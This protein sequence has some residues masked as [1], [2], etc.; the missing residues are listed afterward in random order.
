[1]VRGCC[2]AHYR[3]MTV[4]LGIL[5]ALLCAFVTNLAFLYKHRG[6]AVAP[7]VD[8]RRPI[9]SAKGLFRS[10]WFV[11]G[12]LVAV[13]AWVFHV[14][15]LAMAPI[16]VVQVVLASGLVLLAV[17][18]ERLFGFS[19]GKRQWAALI[20]MFV[21]LGLIAA[22]QPHVGDSNT[23]SI[24]AMQA[25]Q[26]CMV[27][28]GA[29]LIV[30][31]SKLGARP[32]SRGLALGAASGVLF[33]VSDVALKALTGQ[34]AIEGPWGVVSPSVPLALAASVGAFYASAR[35]LQVGEAVPVIA[36]TGTAANMVGI[37]GGILV[38]GDP[39]PS[40]T[41]GIAIQVFAFLL[42]IVAGAL[43]PAPVRAARV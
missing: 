41:M 27:A 9:A 17:M 26:G 8:I 13:V 35:A 36:V 3:D 43:T 6:A 14:L 38:F 2:G 22:T 42:V 15:A 23:H 7:P 11:I 32:Q 40:D 29:L 31:P 24:P 19:V 16:S 34:Y 33:G 25:F 18:A 37:A 20:L 28:I 10:R 39:L 5:F 1:M 4:E 12:W 30:G 21:G